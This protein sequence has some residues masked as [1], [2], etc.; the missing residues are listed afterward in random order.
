MSVVSS[1]GHSDRDLLDNILQL[2]CESNQFDLDPCYSKGN[3]HKGKDNPRYC[4]DIEPQYP[5]VKKADCRNLPIAN[6]SVASTLCSTLRLCS[7]HT[8]RPRIMP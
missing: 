4:Y 7:E 8:D 1:V 5:F 6:N 2:H 3:F